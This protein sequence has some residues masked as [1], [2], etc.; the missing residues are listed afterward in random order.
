[1]IY[2][3]QSEPNAGERNLQVLDRWANGLRAPYVEHILYALEILENRRAIEDVLKPA[4]PGVGRE[5]EPPQWDL[6]SATPKVRAKHT[7]TAGVHELC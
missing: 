3:I 5:I 6:R 2:Q 7:L 4:Y 1:M